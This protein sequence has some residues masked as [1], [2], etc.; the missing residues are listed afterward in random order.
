MYGKSELHFVRFAL[1]IGALLGGAA[2]FL[3]SSVSATAATKPS[4]AAYYAPASAGFWTQNSG[5]PSIGDHWAT[6]AVM[7]QAELETLQLGFNDSTKPATITWTPR[8]FC[9]FTPAP[10]TGCETDT[11]LL[12]LDA[13][14]FTDHSTGRTF[15]GQLSADCTLMA[16]S[17][18]DGLT[19]TNNPAGCGIGGGFDH[20]SFGGGA[21]STNGP[22]IPTTSYPDTF[23]ECAQSLVAD[24]CAISLDGGNTFLPSVQAET[25]MCIGLHGHIKSAPDGTVYLPSEACYDQEP[26][27]ALCQTSPI[28][29]CS[30][31]EAMMV[32]TDNGLH[33]T[34][35]DVAGTL[36]GFDTNSQ[37]SHSD[38]SIAVG[39]A[40]TV[41]FG[42]R[43]VQN[44]QPYIAIS[45][46]KGQTWSTPVNIGAAAGIK[47]MEFA[48]LVSGD[49][50]RAAFSFLGTS[51]AGDDQASTFPGA[52]YLYVAYTYDGGSTWTVVNATP[53]DPVQR[54]CIWLQGGS[55][56]CR[57]MLDFND[58][59]VSK[60]G[61]VLVAFT[62][63]CSGTC[64]APNGVANYTT[65]AAV[66][67]QQSGKGMFAAYDAAGFLPGN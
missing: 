23:Y 47:N 61:R 37:E 56:Q 13:I 19:W 52:W 62:D 11:T 31:K 63:G 49:D 51:T 29:N 60:S 43:N 25:A 21:F 18:N 5:E 30:G 24:Q 46:D 8:A 1:R 17:D 57:N 42:Y 20:E 50:N 36:G 15:A 65:I 32:S 64:D 28:V 7:Y 33:W 39:A 27:P 10:T 3:S 38:P 14:L 16:Y 40:G 48:S 44:G 12:S 6:G 34:I 58:A 66:A 41:Y 4:L 53:N 54:G 35:R 26:N 55:N 22:L 9:N 45:K 67:R 2:L 59:T